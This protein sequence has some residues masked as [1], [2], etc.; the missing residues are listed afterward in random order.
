MRCLKN[1]FRMVIVIAIVL[2]FAGMVQGQGETKKIDINKASVEE[3]TQLKGIGESYAKR[4]VEYRE[5][6]GNFAKV[7]DIMKVKGIGAKKYESIKD[8]IYVQKTD[9]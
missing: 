1:V 9:K 8:Q 7:E 3:L 4:I 5:T 6:N 2:S